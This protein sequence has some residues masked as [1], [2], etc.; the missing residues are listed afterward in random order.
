MGL[1]HDQ[2]ALSFKI[3]I[4]TDSTIKQEQ[5]EE[6]DAAVKFA[7]M[8]GEAIKG[9]EE[10]GNPALLP[11]MGEI[12]M[13]TVRKFKN[14]R[15]LENIFEETI[16]KLAEAPPK[17]PKPDPAQINAQTK[18]ATTKMEIQADAQREA[19][20]NQLEVGHA[21]AELANTQIK[22][23][24][25]NQR[26]QA[27]LAM[28][29]RLSKMEQDAETGRQFMKAQMDKILSHLGHTQN[30]HRDLLDQQKPLSPPPVAVIAPVNGAS[31]R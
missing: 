5:D 29:Q 30:I 12:L 19:A 6:R 28:D 23:Q 27:E 16:K 25:E 1:L 9:M 2:A 15:S 20:K 26:T 3:D 21:H 13:F 17:P 10:I 8:V 24:G 11:L 22:E 4:E 7:E 18:I 14:A 31:P